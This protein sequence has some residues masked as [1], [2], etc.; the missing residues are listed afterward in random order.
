VEFEKQTYGI[1]D[2]TIEYKKLDKRV[3]Y[4]DKDKNISCWIYTVKGVKQSDEIAIYNFN[5][6]SKYVL[7]NK[8]K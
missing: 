6:D 7:A 8:Q 3:G 4:M 1:S 5:K 2:Q